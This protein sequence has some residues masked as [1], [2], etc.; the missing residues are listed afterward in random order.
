MLLR[1]V[2]F[3]FPDTTQGEIDVG[4]A[5]EK[6]DKNEEL[7]PS[8]KRTRKV[9]FEEDSDHNLK[10][11]YRT[12]ENDISSQ[13]MDNDDL[14]EN[15][16]VAIG[17]HQ[18]EQPADILQSNIYGGGQGRSVIHTDKPVSGRRS[19]LFQANIERLKA[20]KAKHG[21]TNVPSNCKDD[22][23]LGRWCCNMRAS[24]IILTDSR[25]KLLQEVVFKFPD[26]IQGK[27]DVCASFKMNLGRLKKFKNEFGHTNVRSDYD[28]ALRKW[29]NDVRR[30]QI[31]MT[32]V[33][34]QL[35]REVG[36]DFGETITDK[37]DAVIDVAHEQTD[38]NEDSSQNAYESV[39]LCILRE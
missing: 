2:G 22:P 29:C 38:K 30:G 33:R 21:H 24:K 12:N 14:V 11:P 15:A 34:K 6:I 4:A 17:P 5:V 20:F 37:S 36:I 26:T 16:D 23:K 28:V 1:E 31:K 8:K 35:L 32:E 19:A 3:K 27:I 9:N 18:Q 7:G 13:S 10:R 39:I 25:I